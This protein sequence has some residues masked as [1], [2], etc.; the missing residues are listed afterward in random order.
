MPNLGLA[1]THSS[2]LSKHTPTYSHIPGEEITG[3]DFETVI[4]TAGLAITVAPSVVEPEEGEGKANAVTRW[5]HD[6]LDT[7]NTC[8]RKFGWR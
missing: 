7:P 1:L 6:P 2:K 8:K 3:A 4:V 5:G